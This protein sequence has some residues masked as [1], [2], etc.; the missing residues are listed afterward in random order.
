MFE[1]LDCSHLVV[2]DDQSIFLL[3]DSIST[4]FTN[5]ITVLVSFQVL[6]VMTT[7]LAFIC[8]RKFRLLRLLRLVRLRYAIGEQDGENLE[9]ASS[10]ILT[11]S[12]STHLN[13]E[14]F[15]TVYTSVLAVFILFRVHVLFATCVAS[16]YH[17]S[18]NP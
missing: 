1:T 3:W 13:V 2:G 18:P 9:S 7:L 10:M 11:L 17:L 5:K 4:P 16:A 14:D 12:R 15:T 6:V 8:S